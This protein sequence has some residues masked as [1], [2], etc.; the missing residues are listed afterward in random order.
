[1]NNTMENI[2]GMGLMENTNEEIFNY[3]KQIVAVEMEK[4]ALSEEVKEIKQAAKDE[5]L[6]IKHIDNA[7]K[8]V[9]AELK[10]ELDPAEKAL[11][12]EMLAIIKS[13]EDLVDAI[14]LIV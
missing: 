2:P 11:K 10:D 12:D 3:A 9:K 13:N 6:L 7:I 1:M 8:I 4:K 5:G 14:A